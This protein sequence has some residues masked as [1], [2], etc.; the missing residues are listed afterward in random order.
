VATGRAR[1]PLL[2]WIITR[3]SDAGGRGA[4]PSD[5]DFGTTSLRERLAARAARAVDGDVL[6]SSRSV[7]Q[8][9]VILRRPPAALPAPFVSVSRRPGATSAVHARTVGSCEA[10]QEP[11]QNETKR[12]RIAS[13]R[14]LSLPTALHLVFLRPRPPMLSREDIFRKRLTCTRSTTP[15]PPPPTSPS[16]SDST[17]SRNPPWPR[18]CSR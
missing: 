3:A 2:G 1:L 18:A 14:A 10:E 11:Q 4:S 8:S 13:H 6:S 7:G 16:G 17:R 15:P 9:V 12:R 5:A